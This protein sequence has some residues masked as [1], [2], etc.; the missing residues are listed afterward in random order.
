M[1]LFSVNQD[2]L[3]QGVSLPYVDMYISYCLRHTLWYFHILTVQPAAHANNNYY[4]THRRAVVLQM[5]I[6]LFFGARI[7][8][9]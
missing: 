6:L 3:A 2:T 1:K 7:R 5:D 9:W 4:N 8:N